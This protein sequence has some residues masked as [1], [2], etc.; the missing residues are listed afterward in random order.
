MRL[1]IPLTLLFLF[2]TACNDNKP[3]TTNTNAGAPKTAG[4]KTGVKPEADSQ[5][6]VIETADYGRIVVELYPNIA[7]QMVERFKKLIGEKFYDGTAIH[8]VD[9]SLGIIQGGDPNTRENNVAM[10]GGGR[11]P[12]P[13]MRGGVSDTAY[14]DRPA[15]GVSPPA[16]NMADGPLVHT[17][18]KPRGVQR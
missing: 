17:P 15:G 16:A 14:S 1:L 18:C 6:A 11:L 13:K 7:P 12:F 5:V 9:A 2:L 10:Y 3:N 4:V 8:R